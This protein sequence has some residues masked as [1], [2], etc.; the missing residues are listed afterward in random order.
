VIAQNTPL[1]APVAETPA[2]TPKKPRKPKKNQ[3]LDEASVTAQAGSRKRSQ[4]RTK[5]QQSSLGALQHCI[6]CP[7]VFSESG[8]FTPSVLLEFDMNRYVFGLIIFAGILCHW[9]DVAF[10][11]VIPTVALLTQV[12]D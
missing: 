9:P 7:S 11:Q 2:K 1:I 4:R 12:D 5:T 6:G 10:V 8:I 3:M